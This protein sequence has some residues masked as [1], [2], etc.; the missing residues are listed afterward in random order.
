M[1]RFSLKVNTFLRFRGVWG[2]FIKAYLHKPS[3]PHQNLQTICHFWWYELRVFQHLEDIFHMYQNCELFNQ[4]FQRFFWASI[5]FFKVIASWRIEHREPSWESKTCTLRA[6]LKTNPCCQDCC[7]F[8]QH[9]WQTKVC[10]SFKIYKRVRN[11]SSNLKWWSWTN[12]P[13]FLDSDPL[14]TCVH[15]VPQ[16]QQNVHK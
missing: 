12:G 7:L 16:K 2:Y 14:S 9:L 10:N 6:N 4:P 8:S 13:F 5:H 15:V 3:W 1:P 11:F